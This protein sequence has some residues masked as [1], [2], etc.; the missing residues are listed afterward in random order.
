MR[1][2]LFLAVLVAAVLALGLVLRLLNPLPSPE[3]RTV[4]TA[5]D[6]TADTRIG[7]AMAP[8][9][10][11]HPG[12]TG[13][14][15]LGNPREAFAARALLIRASERSLDLQYYIW[16][17]DT[18]GTMLLDELKAA[19]DRGVRV[20]LLLDDN[21]TS[22]LDSELTALDAHPNIEVRLFNPFTVRNPKAIGY[23]MDFARLNRRMHNKSLTADNQATII[24]GRNIGDEYFGATTGSQFADLD[25]LAV[26]AI[27]PQVSA[28][29]DRYWA[30]PSA[31]PIDRIVTRPG[32][33]ADPS[34][35]ANHQQL[36][37]AY[38]EALA[39]SVLPAWLDGRGK[40]L[41][42]VPVRMVSDDPA[43]ALGKAAPGGR[44]IDRLRASLGQPQQELVL[45]SAYFVP[46]ADGTDAL[47]DIARTG[48][49][50]A[51]LT[52]ALNATDVAMVHAGY[53]KHRARLLEGGVQLY[54]LKGDGKPDLGLVSEG[55]AA[56]N[57]FRASGS[58]L[59][60]KTFA[61]DRRQIF[62]GSFNFDPRSANL[63][64]ELGFLIE[65]PTLAGQLHDLFANGLAAQAY[66]VT[67]SSGGELRWT[68]TGEAG[69]IIH[70]SEP[71]SGPLQRAL[72]AVLSRLPIDWML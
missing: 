61:I 55:S 18:S 36:A 8:A 50:V 52:N 68:E 5:L 35:H 65:S 13:I 2:I 60:A 41:E 14:H 6:N 20:R 4:S 7:R 15:P 24:G 19:A 29:F 33:P 34:A 9:V 66:S 39:A 12:L 38:A 27:V 1:L 44:L 40:S 72:I 54:E 23:A 64:T 47:V 49:R 11:A 46:T 43:K 17:G 25:V 26:G 16:H 32:R 67:L 62:V 30:S 22:G 28:D 21:G 56:R 45:V 10:A 63:N 42:W 48:T 59:H 70:D 37:R 51:V 3:G 53:A 69:V 71:H 31:L 57:L 58:S